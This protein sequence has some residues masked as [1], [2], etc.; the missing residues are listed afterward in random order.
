MVGMATNVSTNDGYSMLGTELNFVAI[1]CTHG[2]SPTSEFNIY[3]GSNFDSL[4]VVFLW[5]IGV[6]S[7]TKLTNSFETILNWHSLLDGVLTHKRVQ[8]P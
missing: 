6:F 1:R 2:E 4:Q 5:N 8:M 7:I 3:N